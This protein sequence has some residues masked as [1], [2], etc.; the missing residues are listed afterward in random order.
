MKR[1]LLALAVAALLAAPALAPA[2]MADESPS[3]QVAEGEDSAA[4]AMAMAQKY[5]FLDPEWSNTNFFPIEYCWY[6]QRIDRADMIRW[7][8]KRWC[9]KQDSRSRWDF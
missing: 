2:A 3:A 6:Y 8:I 5:P 4:T 1:D 7:Q 9:D